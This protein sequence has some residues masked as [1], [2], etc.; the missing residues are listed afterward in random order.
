MHARVLGVFELRNFLK[1]IVDGFNDE[2]Y[3]QNR[4][5]PKRHEFLSHVFAVVSL[6]LTISSR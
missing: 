2:R 6:R 1:L 5:F 4:Y 3:F